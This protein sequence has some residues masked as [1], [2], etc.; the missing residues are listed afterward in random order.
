MN[1]E[2]HLVRPGGI[3][4]GEVGLAHTDERRVDRLV[5]AALRRQCQT[6]G[7]A[8]QQEAAVRVAAIIER[9]EAARNERIIDRAHWQQPRAE[10]RRG[11]TQRGQHQEEV[12]L[13]DP[14]FDMLARRMLRPFLRRGDLRRV[15]H[16]GQFLPPEQ[17]AL[18]DK[19]AKVRRLG[20]IRRGG[21]DA[22]GQLMA[23]F[24][25]IKQYAPE[26]RLRRLLVAFRRRNGG[27]GDGRPHLL[28]PDTGNRA[29][30]D[31]GLKLGRD[32]V[33]QPAPLFP[34]LTLRHPH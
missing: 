17:A 30:I 33:A 32:V 14:Q 15:E 9:I 2:R 13:R 12:V 20:H 28:R 11:Q 25:Q 4:I 19:G 26:C 7:C 24:C 34:L 31:K 6:R 3:E 5:G 16:I 1:N 27:H 8:D 22:V 21:D 10:M 18:I 23:R 29:L